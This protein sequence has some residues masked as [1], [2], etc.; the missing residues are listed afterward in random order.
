MAQFLGPYAPY[1]SAIGGDKIH[2]FSG[3]WRR[4]W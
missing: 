3:W 1:L 4:V 2:P